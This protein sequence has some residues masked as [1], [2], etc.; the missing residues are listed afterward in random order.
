MGGGGHRGAG[1]GANAESVNAECRN[2]RTLFELHGS[3]RVSVRRT[4]ALLLLDNARL[5]WL[6]WLY[7][8]VTFLASTLLGASLHS[9]CFRS[10]LA[11]PIVLI[12]GFHIAGYTRSRPLILCFGC[13]NAIF[14][15]EGWMGQWGHYS[16][17]D[18]RSM[19]VREIAVAVIFVIT[20]G[21]ATRFVAMWRWGMPLLPES[22]RHRRTRLGLCLHCGYDLRASKDRCPECGTT[23]PLK[24]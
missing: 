10:L 13:V 6:A 20:V 8:A 11:M 23:I 24:S 14:L 21:M 5:L 2:G 15:G 22:R 17:L 9:P 3:A 16:N 4:S 12:S 1:G 19:A 18:F 7:S